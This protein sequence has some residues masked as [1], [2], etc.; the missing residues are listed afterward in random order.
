V[1]LGSLGSQYYA[2][3]N[4]F[5]RTMNLRAALVEALGSVQPSVALRLLD[6][7]EPDVRRQMVWYEHSGFWRNELVQIELRRYL[8]YT[9]ENQPDLAEK[10]LARAADIQRQGAPSTPEDVEI[11]KQVAVRLYGPK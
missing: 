1:L 2:L 4:E 3:G 7:Y 10:A 9:R 8:L 11:L 5:H 6:S